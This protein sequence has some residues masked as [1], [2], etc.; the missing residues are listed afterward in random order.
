[1][2]NWMLALGFVICWLAASEMDYQDALLAEATITDDIRIDQE[3]TS[4]ASRQF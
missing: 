1:M 2:K 4:I 3:K